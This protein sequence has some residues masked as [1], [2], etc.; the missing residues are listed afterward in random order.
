M[1]DKS[2]RNEI[3]NEKRAFTI[4]YLIFFIRTTCGMVLSLLSIYVRFPFYLHIDLELSFHSPFAHMNVV[5]VESSA[6][7]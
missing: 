4:N 7:Q 6:E 1:G 5:A 2:E 3:D